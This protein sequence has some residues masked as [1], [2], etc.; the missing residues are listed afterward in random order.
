MDKQKRDEMIK[1]TAEA[2]SEGAKKLDQIVDKRSALG[3]F[4]APVTLAAIAMLAVAL[5]NNVGLLVLG[6]LVFAA[7]MSPKIIKMVMEKKSAKKEE[8]K[9]EAVEEKK[10]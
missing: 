9:K 5:S 8:V 2:V 6:G 4:S 3:E 10:E 1:K 7:A